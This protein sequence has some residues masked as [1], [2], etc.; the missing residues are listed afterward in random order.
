MANDMSKKHFSYYECTA[1]YEDGSY[2][3]YFCNTLKKAKSKARGKYN[4]GAMAVHA[5]FIV[6]KKGEWSRIDKMIV[7]RYKGQKFTTK[8]IFSFEYSNLD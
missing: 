6:Q 3:E 8:S 2:E 4:A 1:D 5:L 7:F